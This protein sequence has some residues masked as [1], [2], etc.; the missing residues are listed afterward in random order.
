MGKAGS[1]RRQAGGA[2]EAEFCDFAGTCAEADRWR[3]LSH[4]SLFFVVGHLGLNPNSSGSFEHGIW[5]QFLR[6]KALGIPCWQ[7]TGWAAKTVVKMAATISEPGEKWKQHAFSVW[8]KWGNLLSFI[9]FFEMVVVTWP[10]GCRLLNLLGFG[11]CCWASRQWLIKSQAQETQETVAFIVSKKHY[12]YRAKI[13]KKHMQIGMILF[14]T[15]AMSWLALLGLFA[16]D[17]LDKNRMLLFGSWSRILWR[18]LHC[19]M[20]FGSYYFVRE[21]Q[22]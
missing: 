1:D 6:A 15:S 19:R 8:M 3:D 16:Q 10:G 22:N 14:P 9:L 20:P 13:F 12:W 18:L 7:A 21:M 17:A 4:A 2:S 5:G 11:S